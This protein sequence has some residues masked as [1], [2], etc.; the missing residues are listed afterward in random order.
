VTCTKCEE[1]RLVLRA[2]KNAC[3]YLH[4]NPRHGDFDLDV[5]SK[6]FGKLERALDDYYYGKNAT[7]RSKLKKGW[8]NDEQV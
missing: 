5:C 7:S 4:T 8:G 2:A 6:K 1:T 3:D